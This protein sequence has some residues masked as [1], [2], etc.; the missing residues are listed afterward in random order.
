MSSTQTVRSLS[1]WKFRRQRWALFWKAN[2]RKIDEILEKI[3]EDWNISS[4]DIV[5]KLNIFHQ[6]VLNHL[7]KT[8]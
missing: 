4:H 6:S 2:Y 3:E 1:F 7:Q 5:Y 8:G